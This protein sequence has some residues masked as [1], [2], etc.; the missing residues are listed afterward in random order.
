MPSSVAVFSNSVGMG[1]HY[2]L[3]VAA[4]A[5]AIRA[6]AELGAYTAFHAGTAAHGSNI[7]GI[8]AR[9]LTGFE[10]LIDKRTT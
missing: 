1:G 3:T 2:P 7:E 6:A 4:T 5:R 8:S 10:Q 9:G